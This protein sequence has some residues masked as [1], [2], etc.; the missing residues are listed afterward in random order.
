MEIV[1][2]VEVSWGS[3]ILVSLLDAFFQVD[4]SRFTQPFSLL[5]VPVHNKDLGLHLLQLSLV[6]CRRG[7][8]EFLLCTIGQVQ[9][10]GSPC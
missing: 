7:V 2:R 6:L 3:L 10:G 9:A 8:A 1:S 4:N 5:F